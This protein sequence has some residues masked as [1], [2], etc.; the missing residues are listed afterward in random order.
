MLRP[1]S[2]GSFLSVWFYEGLSYSFG[3]W[4]AAAGVRPCSAGSFLSVFVFLFR[5]GGFGVRVWEPKCSSSGYNS[6]WCAKCPLTGLRRRSSVFYASLNLG[7]R[8]QRF[9]VS[10][11]QDVRVR[12]WRVVVIQRFVVWGA[13]TFVTTSSNVMTEP[14]TRVRYWGF[15]VVTNSRWLGSSVRVVLA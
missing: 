3:F 2:T 14:C 7:V 6:F 8:H 4:W 1:G 9:N 11:L 13:R 10:L 12:W 5:F 15:A